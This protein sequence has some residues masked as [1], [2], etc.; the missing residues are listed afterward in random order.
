MHAHFPCLLHE[1]FAQ[2][3]KTGVMSV[4]RLPGGGTAESGRVGGSTLMQEKRWS[5]S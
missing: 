1:G 2:G 3:L 5:A 4:M